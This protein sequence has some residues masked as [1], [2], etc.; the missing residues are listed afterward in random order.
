MVEVERALNH[1]TALNQGPEWLTNDEWDKSCQDA[2]W[3]LREKLHFEQIYFT[4]E[5]LNKFELIISQAWEIHR[6]MAGF[7]MKNSVAQKF[8]NSGIELPDEFNEARDLWGKAWNTT[9]REFVDLRRDLSNEFRKILG[10]SMISTMPDFG[11]S[12]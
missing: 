8:H 1:L 2:I 12:E 5:I 4:E 11:A 7:R 3:A 10:I 9:K 6:T